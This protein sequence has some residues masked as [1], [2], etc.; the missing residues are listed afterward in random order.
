MSGGGFQTT[1]DHNSDTQRQGHVRRMMTSAG[2]NRGEAGKSGEGNKGE[3]GKSGEVN[4]GEA[5]DGRSWEAEG[6]PRHVKKRGQRS[7]QELDDLRAEEEERFA[8]KEGK[9]K[10]KADIVS[11]WEDL[12]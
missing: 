2:G 10:C 5:A 12:E 7:R 11:D 8:R 3:A 6:E 9:P 1:H 4:R